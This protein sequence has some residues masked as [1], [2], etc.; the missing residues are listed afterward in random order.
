MTSLVEIDSLEILVI[1]DN[2]VDPI[3]SY[4]HPDLKVSGQLADV[5]L[6]APLQDGSRGGSK[7]EIRLDNVC[8]GAHGLSLMITAIK[9]DKRHTI[10]FDTAP[11]EQIWELNAKR[12]R[13]DL[14][15]IERIHLSHWHRDHSGGILR[16]ISMINEA[17]G[18]SG[19]QVDLHPNRPTYR[20]FLGPVGPVSLERDPTF[21]EIESAGAKIEKNDQAHTVLEDMFLVSGEIARITPYEK[22]FQRGMR[23]NAESG[24]W[25][26]DELI[27]DERFLMCNVRGKGIVVFTG[28]SHAGVVNVVKNALQLAGGSLP[29]LAVVGGYHLV[30]PNEAFIKDTVADLKALNPRILMPG[31]C[32]GWR[33]KYE[34]EMAMPG[35][36]APSTVG[37]QFVL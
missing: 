26:S 29:L 14:S 4:Q 31:H 18:S 15:S 22:G 3:S 6:R 23:F 13:A 24:S 20:G 21:E 10:L 25:E 16:A 36:L 37:T 9:G 17:K 8:C 32:S 5:A 30:G 35:R 19:I 28:C 7:F 1:V 27:L 34:I 12:L 11:E 33:A 2:E